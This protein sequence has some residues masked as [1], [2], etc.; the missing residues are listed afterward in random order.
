MLGFQP[1]PQDKLFYTGVG[2]DKRVRRNHPLR[3]IAELVDFDFIYDKVK[4]KYGRNGNVGAAP[5][6]TQADAAFGSL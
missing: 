2:L 4:D 1:P 5:G 6:N 3:R